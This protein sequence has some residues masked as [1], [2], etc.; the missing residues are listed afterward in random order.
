MSEQNEQRKDQEPMDAAG[1]LTAGLGMIEEACDECVND[2]Q[3]DALSHWAESLCAERAALKAKV[4]G[5]EQTTYLHVGEPEECSGCGDVLYKR[6][7]EEMGPE[8]DP[9]FVCFGCQAKALKAENEGLHLFAYHMYRDDEISLGKLAELC[10]HPKPMGRQA[11]RL[12]RFEARAALE[13]D[14]A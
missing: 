2:K 10:G 7:G 12:E 1:G 4:A 5:L 3:I 13:A 8:D 11:A 9:E 6:A 14:H